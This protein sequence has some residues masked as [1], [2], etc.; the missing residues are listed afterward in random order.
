MTKDPK[1]FAPEELHELAAIRDGVFLTRNLINE[2]KNILPREFASRL[3]ELSKFGIKIEILDE[4]DL[5]NL[6]MNAFLG[7]GQG[8]SALAN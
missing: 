7:V 3:E 8:S 4:D 2:R 5:R 1:L 6:G